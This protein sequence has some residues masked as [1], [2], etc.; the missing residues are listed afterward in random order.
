MKIGIDIDDTTVVTINSMIKYGKKYSEEVLKTGPVVLNLGTIKDRY[1]MN[2]LFGWTEET[3][4]DF[5]NMYYKDVLEDCKPLAD[6]P[7]VIKALKEEG[8][9][10]Y[11]I[12]ARIT[13]IPGCDAEQIS[14]D[15]MNKYE[16]PY[17]KV[18][19]G[20]YDKLDY[21][22]DNGIEVFVDD[23]LEVLEELSK[24][25]IRCY[26]MT[27][28]V[29]KDLETGSIKRVSTWEEIYNDLQEVLNDPR[30]LKKEI[31]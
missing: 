18:I 24:H 14:I 21:C 4:F 16:I 10:I 17:D 23:S 25:G 19:I 9:E 29:N 7:K 8:N 31:K 26:L 5:F 2:A 3:K 6:S 15:T 30:R 20:A 12:S 28:P 22:L 1:Y 11:F 13:S 27:S